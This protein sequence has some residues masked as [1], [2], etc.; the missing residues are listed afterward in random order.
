MM[1]RALYAR[2][3]T[4]NND[5]VKAPRSCARISGEQRAESRDPGNRTVSLKAIDEGVRVFMSAQD[6]LR[7]L[8]LGFP[9]HERI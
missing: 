9:S 4:K 7:R 1:K 3:S 8:Q 5:Q 6:R 2:V